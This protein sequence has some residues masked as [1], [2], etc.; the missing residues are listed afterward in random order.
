MS[1]VVTINRALI[2][3]DSLF[4]SSIIERKNKKSNNKSILIVFQQ[5][6]G[7]SI[8][9]QN[10]LLS[11]TKIF[12]KAKGYDVAFLV[13]PSV[14]SFMKTNLSLPN[15]L[16]FEELDF[17]RFL[18]NYKY[19]KEVVQKYRGKAGTVI[20]PG[21]SFSAE[22]FSAVSD[23][24]RKIGL[25][26]SI[27]VT[28][29][30]IMAYF[31]RNAYTETIIP[32][33][34]DMMLQRHRKLINYLGDEAYK[35]RLPELL[36]KDRIIEGKYA[37]ICPGS[38]KREKCWPIE[39]FTA[40]ADYLIDNYNYQIHICGGSGEEVFAEQMK[41][42]SKFSNHLISH[43]GT[44]S[45]SDWS[46]IIQY[47][48]IVIG[49]DSATMHLAAAARVPSVCI[50]GVYDKYQFFPYKVD[51]LKEGDILPITILKDMPCEWCRTMGYDAGFGNPDC[52]KK[53]D[54]GLCS[55]CID[56]ISV[57][58][59]KNAIDELLKESNQ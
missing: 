5:I 13:R 52:K 58:E 44:T 45:F 23:A 22:V 21:T 14:L 42:Q 11:Y 29:P 20:V 59:V 7:D 51:E 24:E 47:A 15:E 19:Y 10:S 18:E 28:K 37:V 54:A 50:A 2:V 41:N 55:I 17:M 34:E 57:D 33:K 48:E 53:I 46:A 12:P 32:E 39:K 31:Y 56:L 16:F 26:R 3:I 25:I 8:V 30:W 9:I 38:S 36:V 4:R 27:D 6:F 43:I 35:A 49:N 40:I 1:I